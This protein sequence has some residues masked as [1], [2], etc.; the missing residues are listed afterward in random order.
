[1]RRNDLFK[2]F[3]DQVAVFNFGISERGEEL[4]AQSVVE[5]GLGGRR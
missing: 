5:A 1:M 4:E 2:S 3:R